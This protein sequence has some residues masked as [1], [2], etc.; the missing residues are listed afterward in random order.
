MDE[1]K[2][3]AIHREIEWDR[4][5][6][7]EK[8]SVRIANEQKREA[9]GESSWC[10]LLKSFLLTLYIMSYTPKN[11]IYIWKNNSDSHVL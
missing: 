9:K 11:C 6:E 2:R 4:V 1:K 8:E 5:N 10:F 3:L 7:V